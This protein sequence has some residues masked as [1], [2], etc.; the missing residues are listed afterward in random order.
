MSLLEALKDTRDN[1]LIYG[2]SVYGEIAYKALEQL[3]V[4]LDYFVDRSFKEGDQYFGVPVI[5]PQNVSDFRKSVIIIASADFYYEIFNFLESMDCE[6]IFDMR[7][8]LEL[9]IPLSVLSNRAKEMYKAKENYFTAVKAT[10]LTI[11]HLGVC[12][13]EKCT[14]K[15][16]DCSFLMQYYSKPMDIDVNYYKNPLDRLVDAVDFISELRIYGGEPFLNKEMYKLIDWYKDNDKIGVISIYTNGTLIPDKKTQMYLK[17]SKVK[18]HISDYEHNMDKAKRLIDVLEQEQIGYFVRRYDE[19][20]DAGN[21]EYR[22]FT[23]EYTKEIY[24]KCF[25]TN[26]YSFLKGK[27]YV[28]PRGAHAANIGAIDDVSE[29][30]VDFNDTSINESSLKEQLITLM[31]HK[32]YLHACKYCDGLDNHKQGVKPAI[33]ISRPLEFD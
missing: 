16:K 27:L 3:G 19:W 23:K 8:L 11:I 9:E 24:Q 13:T 22:S 15:C 26:C 30:Y 12:V 29:D 5:S 33:Q 32:E 28:C 31:H 20:Q 4:K 21:L 25:A 14:L 18:V 2:A 7:Q 1:V 6:Q 17:N 10:E